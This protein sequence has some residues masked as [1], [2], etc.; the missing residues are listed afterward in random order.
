MTWDIT[1]VVAI[2]KMVKPLMKAASVRLVLKIKNA[3]K[4]E[5]EERTRGIGRKTIA[6]HHNSKKEAEAGNCLYEIYY[7]SCI[8][9]NDDGFQSLSKFSF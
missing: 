9:L 7:A 2:A 5:V 4:K 8:L 1:H 6:I 3:A